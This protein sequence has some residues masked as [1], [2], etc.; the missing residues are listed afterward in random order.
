M[1]R[2]AGEQEDRTRRK[3]QTRAYFRAGCLNETL[4]CRAQAQLKAFLLAYSRR[5]VLKVK[6]MRYFIRIESIQRK[7]QAY[8]ANSNNRYEILQHAYGQVRGLRA[9]KGKG[10][11][12]EKQS[13]LWPRPSQWAEI[14]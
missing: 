11:K 8:H 2:I 4:H 9:G 5:F 1:H 3:L 14:T 13:K 12:Q 10:K 7:F 6:I